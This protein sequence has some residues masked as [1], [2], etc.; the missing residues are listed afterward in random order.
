MS[1]TWF[2]AVSVETCPLTPRWPRRSYSTT[3][4]HWL[5]SS[6]THTHTGTEVCMCLDLRSWVSMTPRASPS[7]NTILYQKG[8]SMSQI[9]VELLSLYHWEHTDVLYL[10]VVLDG[11]QSPAGGENLPTLHWCPATLHRGHPP[12][13]LPTTQTHSTAWLYRREIIYTFTIRCHP[14]EHGFPFESGSS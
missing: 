8:A 6:H 10:S 11:A 2:C 7:L 13:T 3:S 12:Q 5:L 9:L 14:D 1:S 4:E